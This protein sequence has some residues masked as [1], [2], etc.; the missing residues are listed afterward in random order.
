MCG[1]LL[2]LYLALYGNWAN[3]QMKCEMRKFGTG[4]RGR[5]LGENYLHVKSQ[6]NMNPLNQVWVKVGVCVVHISSSWGCF[7]VTDG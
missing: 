5:D 6:L 1:S 2:F 7:W 4:Q 3:E